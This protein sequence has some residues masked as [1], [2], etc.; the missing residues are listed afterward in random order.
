MDNTELLKRIQTLEEIVYNH[1]HRGYDMT[2]KLP[3][4]GGG[5]TP[6]G[7]D[8]QIQFNDGGVFGGDPLFTYNK[9]AGGTVNIQAH[10]GSGAGAGGHVGVYAGVGGSTGP[11]GYI[12]IGAGDG[13]ASGNHAGGASTLFAGTGSGTGTGGIVGVNGGNSAAGNGGK[14]NVT[15]GNAQSGDKNGGDVFLTAGTGSGTGHDGDVYAGGPNNGAALGTSTT[16][17]F[18]VIPRCNGVPTGIPTTDGS[19]IY[20]YA[21]DDLYVYRGGWLIIGQSTVQISRVN[22]QFDSVN[23]TLASITGLSATVISAQSYKFSV[24]LLITADVTGGFKVSMG[25]TCTASSVFYE[26]EFLDNDDQTNS[27]SGFETSLGNSNQQSGDVNHFCRLTG[28]ITVSGT[29]TLIPKFSQQ[30]P[31]GTSSVLVGSNFKVE[32][33]V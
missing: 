13:G 25:G 16:G 12:D 33:I 2:P 31:N 29:G 17:R 20:D 24:D 8:T 27:F 18:F 26:V 4:T 1:T 30:A 10:D 9:S 15:G 19:M 28:L 23:N 3:S 7:S 5:S 22:T 6:G 32:Q 14:A 11:G 21:N